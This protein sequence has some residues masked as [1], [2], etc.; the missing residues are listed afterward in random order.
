ME[1]GK[2]LMPL[3]YREL[4][5]LA[6]A[7]LTRLRPGQSIQPTELVHEVYLRLVRNEAQG[8][9][10]R[11]HFFAAAARAMRE[12]LVDYARSKAAA[13]RSGGQRVEVL[14]TFV[15]DDST[16]GLS[17]EEVLTLNTALEKL[18]RDYPR[19][20]SIV[21]LR[22]FAGFT[23]EQIGERLGVS[24]RTIERDW[25]F[26]KAWLRRALSESTNGSSGG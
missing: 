19:Q 20:A 7:H 16:M 2:E 9:N 5:K 12:C 17:A 8:W 15:D 3:V 25:R 10:S 1:Y 18:E 14:V 23:M 11:G 21:M 6:Y 4:K 13:K 22:Y 26:A 24:T